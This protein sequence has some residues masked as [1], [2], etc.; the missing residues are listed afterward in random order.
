MREAQKNQIKELIEKSGNSFHY[1]VVNFLRTNGWTVLVSPYYNDNLTDKP[2]E[3]DIVA[4]KEFDVNFFHSWLGT[5]NAKLFIECKYINN[6]VVFWFDS[7]N[8]ESLVKRIM[9]DTSLESSRTNS[10]IEKHRLMAVNS[11]AKLFSSKAD[12]SQENEIIYKALNQSLNAMVYYKNSTSILPKNRNKIQKILRTLNYPIIVC[13]GFN[14]LYK[15]EVG[16]EDKPQSVSDNFQLEVNYAYINKDKNSISEYFLIDVVDFG[17]LG[18]FLKEVEEKDIK[19]VGEV[20][21][22]RLNMQNQ[23]I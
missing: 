3:I 6:E 11:V 15:V 14:R 19:T 18:D 17:K 22:W 12:K 5:I 23:N 21:S 16:T 2:R 7:V 9:E 10:S 4:E 8:K 13:N 20:L 1:Q